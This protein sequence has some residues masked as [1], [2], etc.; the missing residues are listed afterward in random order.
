MFQYPELKWDE[1][2]RS[3]G[4]EA[5]QYETLQGARAGQLRALGDVG[6]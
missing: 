1:M 4:W 5:V 6:R 2:C 3:E